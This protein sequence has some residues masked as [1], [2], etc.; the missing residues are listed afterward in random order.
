MILYTAVLWF[1]ALM[2]SVVFGATV[3]EALVVHPAW[4]RKPPES[5]HG[6]VGTPVSRMNLR[7]FWAP[8]AALY[9]LSALAALGAGFVAG[10]EG[11]ALIVS[12]A[13]AVVGVAWTLLYFRPNIER[14]LEAG[15][16][17][18]PAER[19]QIE[20]RRWIRLNWIRVALVTISW[21]G[22]LAAMAAQG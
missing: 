5:F 12:T 10:R 7:P 17:N 4:S 8:V 15:G 13:C 16:G 19:L 2:V 22:A 20:A 1:Y 6:F 18:T 3:Y 21:W 11:V 14:F 9:A